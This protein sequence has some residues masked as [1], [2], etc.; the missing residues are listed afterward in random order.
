MRRTLLMMLT[1]FALAGE[2]SA[3]P[4]RI[5]RA[6]R[7]D[8]VPQSM[9][10]LGTGVYVPKSWFG[11]PA[12]DAAP[13][14]YWSLESFTTDFVPD[15]QF[16]DV[17]RARNWL[18]ATMRSWR[19][20]YSPETLATLSWPPQTLP[21]SYFA[22]Y[23][24]YHSGWVVKWTTSDLPFP[25]YIWFRARAGTGTFPNFFH[26]AGY[27]NGYGDSWTFRV[28]GLHYSFDSVNRVMN[29][30]PPTQI[31]NNC[32]LNNWGWYGENNASI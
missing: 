5:S 19:S 30:Q 12:W 25:N 26:N 10:L 21:P 14:A 8:W 24:E 32:D 28:Q 1:L 20:G 31:T 22:P 13:K 17:R 29:A 3:D 23:L 2:A 9:N 11:Q 7:W 15:V 16:P 18:W 4:W 27:V 6:C